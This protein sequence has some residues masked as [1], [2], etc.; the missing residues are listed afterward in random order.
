MA[1]SELLEAEVTDFIK[2]KV[3]A[4][5]GIK[6]DTQVNANDV[7]AK[8]ESL[9]F[10]DLGQMDDVRCMIDSYEDEDIEGNYPEIAN[11]LRNPN[12]KGY[13]AATMW[14]ILVKHCSYELNDEDK[15]DSNFA[16]LLNDVNDY[17]KD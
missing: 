2:M 7:I 11:T 8:I 3:S 12:K 1:L 9:P 14:H 5:L 6:Q 13:F 4:D 16:D 10:V 17:L 15:G